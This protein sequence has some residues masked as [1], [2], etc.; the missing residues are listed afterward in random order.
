MNVSLGKGKS[1]TIIDQ[2]IYLV[3]TYMDIYYYIELLKYS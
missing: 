2:C 1:A 3:F